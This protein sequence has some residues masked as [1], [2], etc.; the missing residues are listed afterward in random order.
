MSPFDSKCSINRRDTAKQHVVR[1]YCNLLSNNAYKLMFVLLK[2]C[3]EINN[4]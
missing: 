1:D 3:R 2:R 4:N